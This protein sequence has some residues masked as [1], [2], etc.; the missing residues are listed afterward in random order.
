[1]IEKQ[2]LNAKQSQLSANAVISPEQIR[3]ILEALFGVKLA[4]LSSEPQAAAP[5]FR[6]RLLVILQ[7]EVENMAEAQ[8][9]GNVENGEKLFRGRCAQCHTVEKVRL[10]FLA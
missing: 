7:Y 4:L 9:A 1:M 5:S 8:P 10:F 3:Q 6:H 2:G